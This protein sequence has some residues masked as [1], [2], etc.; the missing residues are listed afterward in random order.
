MRDFSRYQRPAPRNLIPEALEELS[1][2][3]ADEETI[4]RQVYEDIL[5]AAEESND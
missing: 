5:Y 1:A 2:E 3:I 4:D